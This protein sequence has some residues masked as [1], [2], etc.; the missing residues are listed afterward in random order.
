MNGDEFPPRRTLGSSDPLLGAKLNTEQ[1]ARALGVPRATLAQWRCR[2]VGP[3]YIRLEGSI[4][5]LAADLIEY[6][7]AR[8]VDAS[9][10]DDP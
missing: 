2:G 1:A 10:C 8:V 6:V 7:R 3:R 4:R 5:Y 9:P